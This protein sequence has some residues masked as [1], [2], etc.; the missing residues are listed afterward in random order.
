MDKWLKNILF[1]VLLILIG[2]GVYEGY[3][4]LSKIDLLHSPMVGFMK[5]FFNWAFALYMVMVAVVIFL[6]NKD[7]AKTMSWLLILFLLP[8]VGFVFYILF[9]QNYRNK[10]RTRKKGALS[11]TKLDQTAT[12]Q[13]EM[14]D[15]IDL[16]G[17]NESYVNNRLIN[18]LLKNSNAPFSVN[19]E[20]E[21]LTNGERTYQ[22]M[23]E[24]MSKATNHIHFEFFIIRDDHIG[25]QIKDLLIQ[26]AKE[27]VKV[28]IIYDS[29]GCWKLGRSFKKALTEAGCEML[30]FF[31]V[32]F[33]ILSRELN[34]RNHR[35]IIVVDGRVGFVGGLNIG[36][37][38]LGKNKHL[39][40]WRDTHLRVL[41]EATYS[42]QDI[43]LSDWNF[44]T[45]QVFSEI[46]MFPKLEECGTTTMQ[47]AASGPDSDWKALL[48]AYFTMIA[49]AEDRIWIT[50]PYLVPE[51]S[52][53]MGLI[54][55]A[56]SGVD[57]KIIIPSKPDH[58]FVYWA[59]K[60]NIQEL[61][62]AGV[63]IYQYQK[64]FIH[65]KI[66]LVDGIGASV[67]TANLDIR[68]L[69]I[70]FEVNAF[71]YDLEIVKRLEQDFYEDLKESQLVD[72]ETYK[73]RPLRHKVLEA[74][75]RL[76]SPIQ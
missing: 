28:R 24:E 26:K 65:G 67:G 35:K 75:G 37:E 60:D 29:V 40:F 15:Y 72:L 55:A 36:D 7:P 63:K 73:A 14:I 69:E 42:L 71:V 64:G 8:I 27:G 41:G 51:E 9:G 76:V 33:P 46:E 59:S 38:Y 12:M 66:L 1:A 48:Q 2:V 6:E 53:K 49:T 50:T 39:G 31:P 4:L 57:V 61:L 70:N 3:F 43:F 54:T 25:N 74:L 62:E 23:I 18:L 19:N 34:Y 22:S 56:L 58:F 13:K 30:P 11:R 47:I 20:V 21:I 17:G 32:V 16:F 44:L 45:N 68:S 10:F 5:I 52:I